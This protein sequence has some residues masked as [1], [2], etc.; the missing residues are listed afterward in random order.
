[1]T[2][3]GSQLC[4]F[5]FVCTEK[6]KELQFQDDLASFERNG[7]D[8]YLK[9]EKQASDDAKV[10]LLVHS[11][12]YSVQLSIRMGQKKNRNALSPNAESVRRGARRR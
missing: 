3:Q 4:V 2:L 6:A 5:S 12:V 11:V 1:V 9:Q 7:V 8:R 10:C